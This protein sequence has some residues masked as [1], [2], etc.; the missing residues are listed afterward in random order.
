[1][2]KEKTIKARIDKETYDKLIAYCDQH[3]LPVSYVIRQAVK[4]HIKN[5]KK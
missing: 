1:M 2:K 5:D 3:E 4:K